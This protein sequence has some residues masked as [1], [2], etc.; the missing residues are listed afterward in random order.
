MTQTNYLQHKIIVFRRY[1]LLSLHL[2]HL[3]ITVIIINSKILKQCHYYE[4]INSMDIR[5]TGTVYI[6]SPENRLMMTIFNYKRCWG[7]EYFK[8]KYYKRQQRL[9]ALI[10]EKKKK[11]EGQNCRRKNKNKE[12]KL[13]LII[14]LF[15]LIIKLIENKIYC[16]G[17]PLKNIENFN[18]NKEEEENNKRLALKYLNEFGHLK[19]PIPTPTELKIGIKS[20]QDMAGLPLSGILDNETI[21]QIKMPRCGNEDIGK[22]NQ[23]RKRF[24]FISRWEGKLK[25]GELRLKWYLHNYTPDIPRDEIRRT[26][27]KA[28]NLWSTQITLKA[29]ESLSL[30]FEEA[31]N[32]EDADITILWAEGDHGD[33]HMFDGPGEDGSNILAHTFYPNYQSKGTLNGD[34]HLDDY[35]K[36]HVGG[37]N[38]KEGSSY[39]KLREAIM[40]PIYR[41]EQLDKIQL[42]MDDKC[43][44]NWSYIGASDICLYIWLLAEVLPKKIE[45]KGNDINENWWTEEE[46]KEENNIQSIIIM[47]EQNKIQNLQFNKEFLPNCGSPNNYL[48]ENKVHNQLAEILRR[49]LGFPKEMAH[50]YVNILCRFFDGLRQHLKLFNKNQSLF[51]SK[52]H[53]LEN[54]RPFGVHNYWQFNE[55][56]NFQILENNF[57]K[58]NKRSKNENI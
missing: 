19:T 26:V 20:F 24:V 17:A 29:V 39:M 49:R 43:A 33:A 8:E 3:K 41:K 5:T 52:H 54:I 34:I 7:K 13:F 28:F 32:E 44:V 2:K 16:F 11:W 48:K 22:L 35:E 50:S 53:K 14:L 25:D 42:D 45:I 10:G 21:K 30:H 57:E 51:P 9:R 23:R 36:W 55:E 1:C 31:E 18:Q 27:N 40:F 37:G 15:Y 56:N 4:L 47:K 38:I 46:Q 58:E 6:V 12:L